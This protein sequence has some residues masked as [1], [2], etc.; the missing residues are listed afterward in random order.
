MSPPQGRTFTL[1][2][3]LL[4]DGTPLPGKNIDFYVSYDGANFNSIGTSVTNEYGMATAVY[5]DTLGATKLW[6]KASF[7]GDNY[8]E[9][10]SAIVPWTAPTSTATPPWWLLPLTVLVLIILSSSH[11]EHK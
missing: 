8:Y 11:G 1:I 4:S 2:A 7:P 9:P 10:S 6:F 5:T 3:V